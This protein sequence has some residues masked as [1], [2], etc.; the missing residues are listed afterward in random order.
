MEIPIEFSLSTICEILDLLNEDN[1]VYLF[2][3]DRLPAFGK[4]E[5]NVFSL[6]LIDG[7]KPNIAT[8][9]T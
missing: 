8:P 2:T 1:Q 4:Y 6:I 7:E 9:K 5:S 3:Y